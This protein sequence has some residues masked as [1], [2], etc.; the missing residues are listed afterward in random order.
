V[1]AFGGVI[2]GF[3]VAS[4]GRVVPP[5]TAITMGLTKNDTAGEFA[6]PYDAQSATSAM[7]PSE[8]AELP[9]S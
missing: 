6:E 1:K 7:T 9:E 8:A 4:S 2:E 5:R 3:L